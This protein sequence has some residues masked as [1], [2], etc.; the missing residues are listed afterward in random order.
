MNKSDFD[1]CYIFFAEMYGV[2]HSDDALIIMK[3]YFPSLD[4][5]EMNKDLK[6]R[7]GNKE[8]NYAI[9]SVDNNKYIISFKG[10][11]SKDINRLFMV[12]SNKPFFIPRT[13]EQMEYYINNDYWFE[14][15]EELI[16]DLTD[17]FDDH[18]NKIKDDKKRRDIAINIVFK[19]AITI[20]HSIL[21]VPPQMIVEFIE[22]EGVELTNEKEV[23]EFMNYYQRLNN[24][25]RMVCNRGFTPH[26]LSLLRKDN[27][28]HS[29]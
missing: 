24:N 27:D 22:S 3:K 1:K 20:H 28:D 19:L 10:Y 5:K 7:L 16:I 2:I 12:Q 15:N 25:I 9:Y 6:E 17:F 14:E 11:G 26:E 4:E 8:L 23:M 29:A 18:L 13:F 21:M